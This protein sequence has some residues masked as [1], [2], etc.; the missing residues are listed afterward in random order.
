MIGPTSLTPCSTVGHIAANVTEAFTWLDWLRSSEPFGITIKY[1]TIILPCDHELHYLPQDT[2]SVLVELLPSANSSQTKQM[3]LV[4]AYYSVGNIKLGSQL[5]LLFSV[6]DKLGW[7]D[8]P[9][10]HHENSTPWT[11][12]HLRGVNL[13]SYWNSKQPMATRS[14]DSAHALTRAACLSPNAFIACILTD[15]EDTRW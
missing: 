3:D 12:A 2:V 6:M 14:S 11:S 4:L 7:A 8:G 9:H 5:E 13:I 15:R 1:I 10:F